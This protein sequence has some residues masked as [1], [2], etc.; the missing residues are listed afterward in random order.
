M[1]FNFVLH[2]VLT[3]TVLRSGK[4][5]PH[6]HGT[7]VGI[8][9]EEENLCYIRD[10]AM[11]RTPKDSARLSDFYQVWIGNVV[12]EQKQVAAAKLAKVL[13]V[14]WSEQSCVFVVGF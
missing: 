4:L 2:P 8:L 1:V 10:C 9:I 7:C 6:S 11:D 5:F 3:F 12:Y 14:L 13:L